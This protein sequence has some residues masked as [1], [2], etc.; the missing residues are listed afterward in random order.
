MPNLNNEPTLDECMK[1]R[2]DDIINRNKKIILMYSGGIDS[3]C[4]LVG[5]IKNYGIDF[6]RERIIICANEQSKRSNLYV[7]DNFINDKFDVISSTNCNVTLA[8]ERYRDMLIV[9]GDPANVFDGAVLLDKIMRLGIKLDEKNWKQEIKNHH[10]V[11]FNNCVDDAYNHLIDVIQNSAA[12]RDY[13]IEN[14]FDFVWWY[15]NNLLYMVHSLNML[16]NFDMLLTSNNLG[17][18]YW[19]NKFIPFFQTDYFTQWS[20]GVKNDVMI[21][22]MTNNTYKKYFKEFIIKIFDCDLRYDIGNSGFSKN[23]NKNAKQ[24]LLLN[25]NY[26]PIYKL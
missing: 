23:L 9:N 2:C 15:N 26:Q 24:F 18:E 12:S 22:K 14:V 16:K 25:D 20:H 6:C 11:L 19:V 3:V 10:S 5:F 7:W 4:C 1:K 21:D 17:K 8:D 13:H